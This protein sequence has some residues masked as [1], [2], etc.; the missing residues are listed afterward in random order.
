MATI[1]LKL[2]A[3]Y[4]VLPELQKLMRENWSLKEIHMDCNYN[5]FPDEWNIKTYPLTF[6]FVEDGQEIK[7][8][9]LPM[10]VGYGGTGPC[11]FAEILDFFEIPYEEE[12][13]F[14]KRKMDSDRHI[15][16]HYTK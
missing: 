10:A 14:T 2:D 3:T 4:Y 7:V 12:D 5:R 6:V 15:R 1:A 11:D 16:L 9:V 8:R 13:I